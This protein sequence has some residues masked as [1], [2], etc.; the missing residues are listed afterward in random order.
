M[1][2]LLEIQQ[3]IIMLYSGKILD[4]KQ[5]IARVHWVIQADLT[6]HYKKDMRSE[7]NWLPY[8]LK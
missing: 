5:N 2:L 6:S 8:E 3:M 1:K 4:Q 7:N